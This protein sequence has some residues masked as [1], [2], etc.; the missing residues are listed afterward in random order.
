MV[1]VTRVSREN[2]LV[3]FHLDDGK[4]VKYNLRTNKCIGKSGKPV[5]NLSAQ[6]SGVMLESLEGKF[7]DEG[8]YRF[9][10]AINGSCRD[11]Y[12]LN[13]VLSRV[14]HCQNMEGWCR[15]GLNPSSSRIMKVP[16]APGLY[17]KYHQLPEA[18]KTV[19]DQRIKNWERESSIMQMLVAARNPEN[20]AAVD[21]MIKHIE[22]YPYGESKVSRLIR[23]FRYNVPATASYMQRIFDREGLEPINCI[24]NLFDYAR[25][26]AQ[27]SNG[28]RFEKYPSCLL[29]VHYIAQQ[30]FRRMRNRVSEKLFAETYDSRLEMKIGQ[31]M[32]I[33]PKK[34]EEILDEAA[35]QHHCVASYI[36][37]VVEGK[38]HILFMR[39]A[40]HPDKSV[41]TLEL[42][43]GKIVQA[44]GLL[45]RMLSAEE[46]SIVA[47]YERR[48]PAALV[49]ERRDCA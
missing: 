13:G 6:L 49:A 40:D 46:T 1:F 19:S 18:D 30:N 39:K 26:Q 21:A 31:W 8:F 10:K 29:T 42:V 33:C 14:Y 43:G 28:E 32:I 15:L 12:T 5:A 23:E 20:Y 37:S 11:I 9:L 34:Q 38:C 35:Q 25:M 17:V 7:E 24:E 36:Q 44:R 45:N 48:L 41:V 22:T 16:E 47:E 2:E 3:V 27:I 4:T